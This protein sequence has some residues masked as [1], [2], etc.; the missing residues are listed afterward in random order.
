VEEVCDRVAFLRRGKLERVGTLDELT[1]VG[2]LVEIVARV[3]D[4]VPGFH[5]EKLSDR[6]V[7]FLVPPSE[8]RKC[9]ESIWAHGGELLSVMR[10]RRSLEEL[11][12]E[13]QGAA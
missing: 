11:Y 2:A 9:I 6:R 12:I 8:E 5:G 13:S 1:A 7:R 4:D 3:P 10:Q